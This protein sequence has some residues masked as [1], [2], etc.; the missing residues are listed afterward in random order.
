LC[1]NL[2]TW[3]PILQLG[4]ASQCTDTGEAHLFLGHSSGMVDSPMVQWGLYHLLGRCQAAELLQLQQVV[5]W[6][7]PAMC[8]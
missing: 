4:H 8:L 1:C 3:L 5:D 2:R 7:C 6:P